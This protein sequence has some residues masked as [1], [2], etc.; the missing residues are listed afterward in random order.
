MHPTTSPTVH[1][2]RMS[3]LKATNKSFPLQANKFQEN[4]RIVIMIF[5]NP[6]QSLSVICHLSVCLS[7]C[8]SVYLS[9]VCLSVCH[10]SLSSVYL[11]HFFSPISLLRHRLLGSS[12]QSAAAPRKHNFHAQRRHDRRCCSRKRNQWLGQRQ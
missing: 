3:S 10:L 6:I 7:V 5:G 1:N 12:H 4:L 8:L 2:A 11:S 9:S